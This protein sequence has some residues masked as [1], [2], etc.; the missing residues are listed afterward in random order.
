[1]DSLADIYERKREKARKYSLWGILAGS[2]L[3]ASSFA[4]SF[5]AENMLVK[6]YADKAYTGDYINASQT[7]NILRKE[8]GELE[9]K[10]VEIPYSSDSIRLYLETIVSENEKRRFAYN[11]SIR[12]L[13]KEIIEMGQ[14]NEIKKYEAEKEKVLELIAGGFTFGCS[15]LLLSLLLITTLSAYYSNKLTNEVIFQSNFARFIEEKSQ[16]GEESDKEMEI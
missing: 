3:A 2:F 8:R 13:E 10:D 1:M 9:K 4:L 16:E 6:K 15:L 7:L 5:K 12:S 11:V 14:R